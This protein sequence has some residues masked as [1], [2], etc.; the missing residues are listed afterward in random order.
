[1][2][3]GYTLIELLI[4]MLLSLLA[5]IA[6][7]RFFITEHNIYTLQEA[8]TEMQQTLRGAMEIL[9]GE[10]MLAGYGLPPGAKRFVSYSRE[11]IEFRT[12]LRNTTTYLTSEAS[13]GET[14][15]SIS[16]GTG[17]LFEK[18]DVI[19]LCR[20]L[21]ASGCEEHT[22]L[23]DGKS[24]S[25]TIS[26][27]L[28][29]AFPVG[30]RIDLINTISYRFNRSRKEIQR[31][32]DRGYWE[33]L[34]EHVAEDGLSFTYRDINDNPPADSEAIRSIDISLTVESLKGGNDASRRRSASTT[35]TLRN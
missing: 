14:T 26:T 32:I 28:S 34:I 5:T 16:K 29:S 12:N 15:L 8:R 31:R 21:T 1:M 33:P 6:I 27:G 23:A 13:P 3:K 11:E 4:A 22:L 10:L 7:S 24:D 9:S 2:D 30:S 18:G 35:V 20:D 19:V 17:Y 25:I